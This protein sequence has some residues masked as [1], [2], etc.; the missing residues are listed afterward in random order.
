[1]ADHITTMPKKLAQALIEAGMQHHDLGGF[2]NQAVSGATGAV[3]GA[4]SPITGGF[5]NYLN[6]GP[7]GTVMGRPVL[8]PGGI[9]SP[10]QVATPQVHQQNLQDQINYMWGNANTVYGQQQG[11]AQQLLAQSQG[12]G[13]NPALAQ[14]NQA[15]GQNVAQQG[16]L[17]AS[18]RGAGANPALIA[19]QAAQA[20]AGAQQQAVGQA[21]TLQ[22]QQQLAAQQQLGQQQANMANQQLQGQSIIQG[23]QAAQNTANVNAQ[24]GAG[25][26]NS[27]NQNAV[28]GGLLGAGGSALA[29]LLNKGGEV[30]TMADGGSV[31]DSIGIAQYDTPA[32]PKTDAGAASTSGGMAGI[33]RVLAG[34]SQGGKVN[35]GQMLA[36]GNVPGKAEIKGDSKKNDVVPTLLSPGEIVLPRSVTQSPNMEAKAVEFLKHLRVQKK[37]YGGVIESRKLAKGGRC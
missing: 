21:A 8:G 35:F 17:A 31:N 2:I 30:K 14:L 20:G 23:A 37:G 3:T 1:M 4:L 33:G 5:T 7:L 10:A 32:A 9:L 25:S 27:Q 18:Q 22:A 28:T 15:T 16:A 12:Q 19:R 26:I 6:N 13:P 29:A 34:L 11:L 36:G 24:L